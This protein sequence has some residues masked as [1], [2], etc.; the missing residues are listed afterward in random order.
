MKEEQMRLKDR[1][2]NVQ[3][4]KY[5]TKYMLMKEEQMKLKDR[6]MNVQIQN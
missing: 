6:R 3:I 5:L 4:Q 1:G 2:V